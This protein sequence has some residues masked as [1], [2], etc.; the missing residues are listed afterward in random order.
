MKSLFNGRWRPTWSSVS[1]QAPRPRRT[2]ELLLESFRGWARENLDGGAID[3]SGQFPAQVV[4]G[5]KEMGM[6]GMTIPRS[7]AA[8][9]A[10]HLVL[11]E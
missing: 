10:D 2:L 4:K 11:P 9:A 5:L 1:R 8:R 3:R 7:T 6:L